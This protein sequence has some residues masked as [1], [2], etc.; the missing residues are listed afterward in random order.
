VE[1][2]ERIKVGGGTPPVMTPFGW[3]VLYH[4]VAGDPGGPDR[5]KKLV[6]SAGVLILDRADPR[7][8]VYRSREPVMT[9]DLPTEKQGL[10]A[11]VVFPTAI[12]Q[13]LDLHRP[14]RF[15]FYYGM[16]DS[17]IG[18]ARL[19]LPRHLPPHA[20]ADAPGEV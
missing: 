1:R 8:I 7:R 12:D 2:W 15:D 9:P 10:V 3:L 4:G 16:A 18:A 6:Y 14:E 20:T 11:N 17:R 5:P 13:R 19:W